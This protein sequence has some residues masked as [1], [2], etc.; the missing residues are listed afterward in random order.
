MNLFYAL[1]LF[2]ISTST[3]FSLQ[4]NDSN[5]IFLFQFWVF[6][7]MTRITYLLPSIV[8]YTNQLLGNIAFGDEEHRIDIS[9]KILN[10]Y[11]DLPV[12]QSGEVMVPLANAADAI[13]TASD[14]VIDNQIPVNFITEVGL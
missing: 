12:H 14:V 1:L 9:Y 8:P 4:Q 6:S 13:R 3:I 11:F 7:V 5:A 2:F 10:N